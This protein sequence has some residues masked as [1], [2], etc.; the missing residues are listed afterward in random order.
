V[1]R[2]WIEGD[3]L[4]LPFPDRYFDAVTVGYGLRNVV[5][6][7]KAMREIYRVL[8]PGRCRVLIS[9]QISVNSHGLVF[10]GLQDQEH[11]Y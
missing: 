4:D 1:N 10:T 2:R 9:F 5:D 7:P 3:A 6:K 8:Q 11:P